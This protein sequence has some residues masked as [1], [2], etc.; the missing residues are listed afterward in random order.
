MP[1]IWK[2][3]SHPEVKPYEFPLAEELEPKTPE[4]QP[5][6]NLQEEGEALLRELNQPEEKQEPEENYAEVQAQ[7][8]LQ[9]AKVAAE[10]ILAEARSQAASVLEAA[11]A[12]G[13]KAGRAEGVEQGMHEAMQEQMELQT[14]KANELTEEVAQF[15]E[16]ATD[17][18]ERQL[19]DNV[20]ELRDLSIAVAEKVIGISLQ[21]S[22]EV[23]ERMIRMAVDKRKRREWVQI[24]VSDKDAK[25]LMKIS[26]MLTGT[27]S[28]L[29]DRVRIIPM[30]ED[31]AGVCIIEMPDEIID[32]SASTQLENIRNMLEEMPAENM[33]NDKL[34]GA[35]GIF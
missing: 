19:D 35:G 14:Q 7:Q 34:F 20:G 31:E 24:Y 4:E 22:S 9:D 23:I 26:P 33:E 6:L 5:Q 25:R 3:R 2:R 12:E 13:F 1:S 27:L 30:A 28:A 29:S 17:T 11:K 15:L 32:A 10:A 16:K 18:L 8:I 21:S